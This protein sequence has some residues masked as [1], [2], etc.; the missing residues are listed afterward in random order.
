[1][2][3]TPLAL[4]WMLALR[5]SKPPG[6]LAQPA[7]MAAAASAAQD[8]NTVVIGGLLGSFWQFAVARTGLGGAQT[9]RPG[10]MRIFAA[11]SGAVACLRQ[12]RCTR[13]PDTGLTGPAA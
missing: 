4:R 3:A 13:R 6:A 2:W 9:R 10:R 8:E 7:S 1:M 5:A 11:C 12:C